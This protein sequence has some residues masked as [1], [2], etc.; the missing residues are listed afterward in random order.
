MPD[1][2][3]ASSN[4]AGGGHFT[5]T[6]AGRTLHMTTGDLVALSD[7]EK[8][9]LFRLAIRHKGVALATLLNRV[10][11]G[12]EATNVKIYDFFG[13][14]LALARSN[15][16][17]TPVNLLPGA[18]G[19]RLFADFTGCTEYRL[20][21]HASIVNGTW[22]AQVV[23]DADSEVLHVAPN[24]GAAGERELDTDWQALPAEFIGEG[25]IPLRVQ[26][27]SGASASATFRGLRLGLR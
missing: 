23:R 25:I 12:D 27:A 10:I 16:G 1:I 26:V 22:G 24:L 4:C 6:V 9:Q 17:A 11:Y 18:N 8:D 5:L 21:L 7:D 3:T 20:M 15:I 19:E 14:G 13:P 2:C